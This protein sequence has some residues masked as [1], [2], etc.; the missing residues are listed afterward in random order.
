MKPIRFVP[1]LTLCSSLLWLTTSVA[2]TATISLDVQQAMGIE[3]ARPESLTHYPSKTYPGEVIIPLNQTYLVTTP[4]SGLVTQIKHV[5][6]PIQQGEPIA[7]VLSPE[8]LNAQKNYLNTLADL[9]A[10]QAELKRAST[11]TQT[12]VVSVKK[13]QQAEANLKKIQQIQTQ[14][15]QDLTLMGMQPQAVKTLEKS[16]QL[17]PALIQIKAPVTGELFDLQVRVGQRLN[18]NQPIISIGEVNPIV[19]ETKVPLSEVGALQP[20]QA[21]TLASEQM[22][23]NIEYIPHFTDPITQTVNVHIE[24]DN[25]Q[26]Q[27]RPGQWVSTQFLFPQPA[28]AFLYRVPRTAIGQFDGQDVL[29]QLQGQTLS[30]Q[31]ITLL[32]FEGDWLYL[33]TQT[34]LQH[35]VVIRGVNALRGLLE[36]EGETP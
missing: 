1:L 24:F 14:Q 22:S 34:A 36:G 27:L 12:G 21:V 5:H 26:F 10:A 9:D 32:N 23:G 4:L 7:E 18:S 11:L 3:V 13:R 31:P 16:H 28:E 33:S 25:A 30:V 19:V 29:F 6:G 20:N 35:A 17:Q 8:L 15:K 2:Q